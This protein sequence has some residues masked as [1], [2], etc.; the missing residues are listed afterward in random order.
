MRTAVYSGSFNPLHIGHLAILRFLTGSAGF[1]R[2]RLVVSPK[3]PLKDGISSSTGQKRHKAA[4]EAVMR[5]ADEFGGPD[6]MNGSHKVIVDSIE[7]SMPEPHYTIRTLDALMELHQE[8]CITLVMGADNLNSITRWRDYGRILTEYGV[9]VYPRKGYM[10]EE[11]RRELQR[12]IP[13]A[14]IEIMNAP[15]VDISSTWIREAIA[16]G[17][18]I[19]AYLM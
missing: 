9:I 17:K 4:L 18:N 5:H 10:L 6:S 7:L 1:D 15:E 2:V 3:N 16:G 14:K 8:E 11:I 13:G 12:D 19:S